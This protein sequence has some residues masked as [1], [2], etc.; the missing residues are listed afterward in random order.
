MLQADVDFINHWLS[1]TDANLRFLRNTMP[2]ATLPGPGLGN[3]DGTSAMHGDEG[4]IFLFNPNLPIHTA[5]LVVDE[6]MGLSNSSAGDSWTVL[7]LFPRNGTAVGR[8]QHGRSYSVSVGGSNAR[9]L[10]LRK[11]PATSTRAAV[12]QQSVDTLALPL[13]HHA[14][15]I[16]PSL[17]ASDNT[18]GHFSTS[19]T[20]PGAIPAQLAARAK[21]YPI[22]WTERD[23]IATWLDPNRLLGYIFIANPRDSWLEQITLTVDGANVQ[24]E[25]SYNSRGLNHSRCFLGYYFDASG[26]APDTPHKLALTLPKLGSGAFT[27]IFWQNV[28]TEYSTES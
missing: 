10:Q 13:V 25:R 8:W 20:I 23:R 21:A 11:A 19:F 28:E 6:S 9:V 5:S 26:L 17:P 14:M 12:A 18:G 24:V 27:G 1:W 3:V 4:Y 22:P 16:S 2:L 7:E 15:P